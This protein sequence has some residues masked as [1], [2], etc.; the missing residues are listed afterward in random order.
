MKCRAGFDGRKM[1]F[2]TGSRWSQRRLRLP[3]AVTHKFTLAI[4]RAVAQRWI[5]RPRD[6]RSSG[7]LR[8]SV[9][10]FSAKRM[11]YLL[12]AISA[13]LIPF[14]SRA[15]YRGDEYLAGIA[16]ACMIVAL[17]LGLFVPR[18]DRHRF[19]PFL[20]G[21]IVFMIHGLFQKL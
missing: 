10:G 6:M 4:F 16:F 2:H 1:S 18:S 21:F 11:A 14:H 7:H 8:F 19:M 15:D 17:I 12:V 13:L 20:L 9:R 3:L 5:V